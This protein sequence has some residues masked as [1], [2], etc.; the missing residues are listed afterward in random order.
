MTDRIHVLKN[1]LTHR[2][3]EEFKLLISLFDHQRTTPLKR[4]ENFSFE[5]FIQLL[6]RHRIRPLIIEYF[7]EFK[8]ILDE[9]ELDHLKKICQPF[10]MRQMNL[11]K[12][13]FRILE[14]F[15]Q[16]GIPVISF[17][18]PILSKKLFDSYTSR[19]S[20]DLD[21]LIHPDDLSK[22]DLILKKENFKSDLEISG[23]KDW[24]LKCLKKIAAD[25]PYQRISD[26]INLELH[27][28]FFKQSAIY[29]KSCTEVFFDTKKSDL[30]I[31]EVTALKDEDELLYLCI[32]GT[33]HSWFRI[34]WLLDIR[35]ILI[36]SGNEINWQQISE[37]AKSNNNYSALVSS[38]FLVHLIFNVP[39]PK[40][41]KL[42]EFSDE[43]IINQMEDAIHAFVNDNL[44]HDPNNLINQVQ[45]FN[46]GYRELKDFLWNIL[47]SK[48]DII[49]INLPPSLF[50][51]YFPLRPFSII[52]RK[53]FSR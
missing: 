14:L 5:L 44:F 32:H 21:F 28:R 38:L 12:V 24:N 23:W 26:R 8:Q 53:I 50:W 4:S 29:P 39:L 19:E 3:S 45:K 22:A 33:K 35:Q 52:Y 9:K 25:I 37:I 36:H 17:K 6:G 42:K 47:L 1:Q 20:I 13:T 30:R 11:T 7:D 40:L 10:V 27:W 46:Y 34:K 43:K 51:L 31:A 16:E 2:M 15:K 49:L 18:G 41:F 48:H